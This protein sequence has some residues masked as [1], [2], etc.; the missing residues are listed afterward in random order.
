MCGAGDIAGLNM[1]SADPW[2]DNGSTHFTA[3][4]MVVAKGPLLDDACG[5]HRP[6]ARLGLA[7]IERCG[8]SNAELWFAT[9]DFS[10]S[11]GFCSPSV[12]QQATTFDQS[13]LLGQD[14]A[15]LEPV[16]AHVAK[17]VLREG[18]LGAFVLAWIEG[19]GQVHARRADADQAIFVDDVIDLGETGARAL[20]ARRLPEGDLE[21]EVVRANGNALELAQRRLSG[22]C[23]G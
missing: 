17:G 21:L 23:G 20:G 1:R 2:S 5:T 7:W 16:L 12:P 11:T 15:R 8:E 14:N 18:K 6:G 19:N 13:A 9:V 3:D 4:H 10:P 22:G